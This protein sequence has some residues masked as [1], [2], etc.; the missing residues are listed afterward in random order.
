MH[1]C[2]LVI[3]HSEKSPGAINVNSG[4]TEFAFNN[5]MAKQIKILSDKVEVHLVYRKT[6]KDLPDDINRLNPDF[7]MSLHCNAFNKQAS[8]T[9]TLYYYKSRKGK[10][11]AELTQ[12]RLVKTLG[13]KD[14]GAHGLTT[15]DRGGYLLRYTLKPC[16]IAEPFFIDNDSD[17]N[18]AQQ[19]FNPL[20]Y[21][22][23]DAINEIS[24]QLLGETL[25]PA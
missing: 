6:Y 4:M 15:E 17:L 10:L 13:L 22:Y 24:A 14:R 12:A 5:K 2:A 9:E 21:A 16:I 7:I 18:I 1:S 23:I 25:V 19:N 8:G 20:C 11:M 3:G